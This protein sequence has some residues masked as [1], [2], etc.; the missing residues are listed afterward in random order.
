MHYAQVT[1]TL[2]VCCMSTSTEHDERNVE[3]A[4]VEEK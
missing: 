4:R 1:K 3:K 2:G